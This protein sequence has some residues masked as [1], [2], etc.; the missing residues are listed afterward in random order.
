MAF[1]NQ[2]IAATTVV[3]ATTAIDP[4]VL[5]L[6]LGVGLLSVLLGVV[7]RG[8]TIPLCPYCEQRIAQAALRGHL[9]TCP[10]HLEFWSRK[11][12]DL[13]SETRVYI[14]R[15]SPTMTSPTI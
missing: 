7:Y 11:G 3:A 14:Q 5:G 10:K 13:I 9:L 15:P 1:L 12:G 8:R 2:T 6:S 4:V